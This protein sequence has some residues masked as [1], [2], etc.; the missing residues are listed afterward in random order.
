MLD[1]FIILLGLCFGSFANVCIWR[2][3]R[4]ESIWFPRSYCP[5][6]KK[7]IVW[8]HNIPVFSYFFLFGKCH[9]CKTKISFQYPLIEILT[10]TFFY[11]LYLKYGISASFFYTSVLTILLIIISVIDYFHQIIPDE[12]SIGIMILGIVSSPW[13]PFLLNIFTA[14]FKFPYLISLLYSIISLVLSGG[15]LY[16][17]AVIGEKIFKRESMG[18]GDIKLIAGIGTFIGIYSTLW[19]LFIGSILGAVIGILLIL[20]S[21]KTKEEPIPF[22]PFLNLACYSILLIDNT[23]VKFFI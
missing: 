16:F 7:Q 3:P 10:S 1:V 11:L 4:N 2:I 15:I 12:L 18:G 23:F 13:N 5:S 20:L 21:K 6:C 8:Y 17:I 14:K 19:V 9:Y 22:G